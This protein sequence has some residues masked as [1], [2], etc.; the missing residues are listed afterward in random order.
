MQPSRLPL[1]T[2]LS[3]Q[4]EVPGLGLLFLE[5]YEQIGLCPQELSFFFIYSITL[6]LFDKV[7]SV[8]RFLNCRLLTTGFR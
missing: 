3:L 1:P 4:V 6:S 5:A 7:L 8:I 2:R